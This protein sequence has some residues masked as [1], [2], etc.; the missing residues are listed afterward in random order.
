MFMQAKSLNCTWMVTF[1]HYVNV[2]SLSLMVNN[3][4]WSKNFCALHTSLGL[5]NFSYSCS[6][7]IGNYVVK[8]EVVLSVDP[9]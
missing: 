5:A 8:G 9:Y 4:A 1:E 7:C 3:G 6:W 2:S